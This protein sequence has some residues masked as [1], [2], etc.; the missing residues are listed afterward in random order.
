MENTMEN[1]IELEIR[2][3]CKFYD[4]YISSELRRSICVISKTHYSKTN[5]TIRS[6]TL[7]MLYDDNRIEYNK[8]I[9]T[10]EKKASKQ[11]IFLGVSNDSAVFISNGQKILKMANQY[12]N[13]Y[14]KGTKVKRIVL[15]HDIVGKSPSKCYPMRPGGI[16][17]LDK[18]Y[19]HK[20]S[21]DGP[22]GQYV[23]E[24]HLAEYYIDTPKV[25][26]SPRNI[27]PKY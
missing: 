22:F 18:S 13:S 3:G 27:T 9:K 16:V 19:Y 14:E 2:E 7:K 10:F 21:Y 20:P 26:H 23:W 12:L 25:W 1:T 15:T 6:S 8:L 11:M 17:G 5:D 24:C 4:L